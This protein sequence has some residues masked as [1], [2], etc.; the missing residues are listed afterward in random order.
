MTPVA[1]AVASPPAVLSGPDG[2]FTHPKGT[3][4]QVWVAGVVGVTPFLSWVR[5]LDHDPPPGTVDFF[6]SVGDDVPYLA[7]IEA[8]I[9]PHP[10]VTLHV[11]RTRVD[12]RLTADDLLAPSGSSAQ[13]VSA[14]MCGPAS[15][16]QSLYAGLRQAGVPPWRIFREHFD[17]R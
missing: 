16:V 8:L 7:E 6:Y 1:V 10:A 12:G 13:G 4:R 17:W 3:D 15:M 2:R 9:D 14:F 5:S 11:V